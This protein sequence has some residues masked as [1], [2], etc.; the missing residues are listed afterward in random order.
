MRSPAPVACAYIVV[1][2]SPPIPFSYDDF[3]LCFPCNTT[4]QVPGLMNVYLWTLTEKM[5]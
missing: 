3:F 1:L 5:F 4:G 2:R